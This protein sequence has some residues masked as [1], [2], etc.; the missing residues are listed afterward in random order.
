MAEWQE[1]VLRTSQPEAL[2]EVLEACEA[3]AVTLKD[4]GD[5]PVLEPAPGATPLWTDTQVVGLFDGAVDRAEIESRLRAGASQWILSA[6]WDDLPEQIWER[7]WLEHFRPMAFGQRL[8][9]APHAAEVPADGRQTLRLDPGLAFGTGTH[10]STALCLHWLGEQATLGPKVLDFGC[11]SGILAI[12]A[13]LLGAQSVRACDI[14][15]QAEIATAENA[16]I[17]GVDVELIPCAQADSQT[18]DL[19]CANILASALISLAPQLT[20]CT[21]PGGTLLLAG[22]LQTQAAAVE[23]AF[24]GFSFDHRDQDEWRLLIGCRNFSD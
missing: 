10:Q 6:R 24:P 17:N 21:R 3:L 11:G 16:R 12:A 1:L 13:A 15:P 7:T 22:L 18:H 4:A 14:D 5:E 19:V 8:R 23:A 2:A 9:V 20:A